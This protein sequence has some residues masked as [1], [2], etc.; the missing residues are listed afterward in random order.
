M[1]DCLKDSYYYYYSLLM[2]HKFILFV[3]QL[4]LV[5][6][7]IGHYCNFLKVKQESYLTNFW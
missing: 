6:Q 7:I 3:Y 1:Y 2:D 4:F 5:K